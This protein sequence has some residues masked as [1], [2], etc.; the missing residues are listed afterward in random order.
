MCRR[1][2]SRAFI[3]PRQVGHQLAQ[4][5][6]KATFPLKSEGMIDAVSLDVAQGELRGTSPT[7]TAASTRLGIH[8]GIV[9]P[10]PAAAIILKNRL[11]EVSVDTW[12]S[13]RII[14]FS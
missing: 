5:W 1:A 10:T 12:I 8:P 13:P 3:S 6:I 9:R 11:L 2:S 4:K 14:Y 7:R